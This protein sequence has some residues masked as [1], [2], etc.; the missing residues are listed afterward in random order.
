MSKQNVQLVQRG[1]TVFNQGTLDELFAL[2]DEIADPDVE[3]RAVG[4]LPDVSAVRGHEAV[5]YWLA[6]MLET[7]DYQLEPEEFIDA[8]D[9]VVVPTRQIARGKTSGVETTNRVVLVFGARKGKLTFF[10]SYASKT[11]ALEAVGLRG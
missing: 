5:K 2:V 9:A 10:D 4:R 11:K 1:L 3:L 7:L 6:Q 8:G